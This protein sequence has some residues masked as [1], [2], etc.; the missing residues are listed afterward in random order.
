ME[1]EK[2]L[3]E[4]RLDCGMSQEDF[5]EKLNLSYEQLKKYE[6]GQN[7]PPKGFTELLYEVCVNRGYI[8]KDKG[9]DNTMFNTSDKVLGHILLRM[10]E[11]SPVFPTAFDADD[12]ATCRELIDEQV[13][14]HRLSDE[15]AQRLREYI[16]YLDI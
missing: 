14:L 4:I 8:K 16:N 15:E 12:F 2:T 11:L 6:Y 5:A 9:A 10:S 13:K 3:K 7:K 1:N